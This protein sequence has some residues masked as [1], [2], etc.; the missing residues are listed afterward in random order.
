VFSLTAVQP[1]ARTYLTAS[2]PRWARPPV[3]TV[4]AEAGA[5]VSN[6]AVVS[7]TVAD[8]YNSAGST[9]ALVD[10]HGYFYTPAQPNLTVPGAVIFDQVHHT[11]T[12]VTVSW[13]RP[14]NGGLPLTQYA[15]T[16]QPGGRRVVVP[17][18]TRTASVDGLTEGVRYT[19][20]AVA[21][22][23]AGDGPVSAPER[24]GP[25]TWLTRVDT[26]ATGEVDPDLRVDLRGISADGRYLLWAAQSRSVLVPAPYR[27]PENQGVYHLRKD[28]RTGAI[29]LL[30]LGADDQPIASAWSALAPDNRTFVFSTHD[31][32]V[33]RDLMTGAV[34]TVTDDVAKPVLSGD[35][36]WMYWVVG[37]YPEGSTLYRHD[38]L[39]D[40]TETL[41][42]CPTPASG[43]HLVAGIQVSGDGATVLINY[44]AT[45]ATQ[46][47]QPTLFDAN[48][49][50]VRAIAGA[51]VSTAVLSGDGAWVYYRCDDCSAYTINKV[52]TTPGALPVRAR[53]W[54]SGMTW[55]MSPHATT[56]DGR[57][58]SYF[59]QRGD[60]DWYATSPG[61][62]LDTVD[63]REA[64]LPQPRH[65]TYLGRPLLSADGSVAV[66]REDCL[67]VVDCSPVGY[68]ALPVDE[69]LNE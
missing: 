8:V 69:L 50:E 2:D 44:R 17:A 47:Q 55:T 19:I 52:A 66:A 38:L 1:T 68:Y 58:L 27:T 64:M 10:A 31:G 63:G 21:T 22:N 29:E 41:L 43:C 35:G 62:I 53:Y 24:I 33:V 54:P 18:A 65:D 12:A 23:L 25:P 45:P 13:R 16:L 42:E 48:T 67:S 57:M 20:T 7:G 5:V 14:T 39:A 3:S 36:R 28:L 60:G 49:R 11:G 4:N 15:V 40:R 26:S 59:R 6:L 51:G 61:L 30:N 32:I 37:A 34:R 56:R 46:F 9:H